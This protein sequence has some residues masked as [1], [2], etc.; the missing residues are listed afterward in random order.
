MTHSSP[1]AVAIVT[2]PPGSS[3]DSDRTVGG[4]G[5][6]DGDDEEQQASGN[7]VPRSVSHYEMASSLARSSPNIPRSSSLLELRGISGDQSPNVS[8]KVSRQSISPRPGARET[9]NSPRSSLRGK[10]VETAMAAAAEGV[11]SPRG[12]DT[13]DEK[14]TSGGGGGGSRRFSLRGRRGSVVDEPPISL[15]MSKVTDVESKKQSIDDLMLNS[16]TSYDRDQVPRSPSI[17]HLNW[18]EVEN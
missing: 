13:G 10:A 15:S 7:Y 17:H 5:G 18:D 4:G 9:L 3:G 11:K 2:A 12:S 16:I 6:S 8:P 14:S 1:A